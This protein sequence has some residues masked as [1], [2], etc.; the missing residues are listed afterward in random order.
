[1]FNFGKKAKD[2]ELTRLIDIYQR[3]VINRFSDKNYKETIDNCNLILELNPRNS[4]AIEFK[5]RALLELENY[6]DFGE[7]IDKLEDKLRE[8]EPN[9]PWIIEYDEFKR[10][11]VDGDRK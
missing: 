10:K 1:M 6:N 5:I 2:E 4:I 3:C 7:E 9:N 11:W 8:I